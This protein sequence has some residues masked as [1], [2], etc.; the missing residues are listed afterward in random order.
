VNSSV[1]GNKSHDSE[2]RPLPGSSW[3][4]DI[5]ICDLSPYCEQIPARK[6]LKGGGF[7]W[8]T[9]KEMVYPSQMVTLYL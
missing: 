3:S 9:V 1:C 2:P 6:Q 4:P 7:M 8:V 5:C